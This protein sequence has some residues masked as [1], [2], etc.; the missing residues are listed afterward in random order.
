MAFDTRILRNALGSFATGVTIVTTRNANGEDVGRTANSFSSVSLEPPMILWSLSK[1]SASLEDFR[2]SDHF[3]VHILSAGQNDLSTR[4]AGKQDDKFAGLDL[5]RG[6][7]DIPLLKECSARFACRTAHQYEGGDHIIFVGEVIDFQ[8]SPTPPL[9]FHAGQYGRL[10]RHSSDHVASVEEQ[11][12]SLSPDDFIYLISRAFYRIRQD[13][14]AERQRR[15]WSGPEI[16]VLTMLGYDDNRSFDQI[17]AI[18][19]KRGDEI[20]A[21]TIH[22]LQQKGLLDGTSLSGQDKL[23]LT[24]EGKRQIIEIIAML[25]SAEADCLSIFDDNEVWILKQLL[26]KLALS[27][28]T[29][30]PPVASAIADRRQD[31]LQAV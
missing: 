6:E 9:V 5:D 18:G 23:S 31:V 3:A 13:A 16:A 7:G 21:A 26:H 8:H 25:K 20:T 4:F 24:G 2:G 1:T 30:W 28:T 22:S 17:K 29:G 15:G 27:D 14:A 19:D 10:V 12:S 11:D